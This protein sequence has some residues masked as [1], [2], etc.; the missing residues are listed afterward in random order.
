MPNDHL[1]QFIRDFHPTP[2]VCGVPKNAARQ[3]YQK[4]ENHQRDL[5]TGIIGWAEP[6]NMHLFVNLRCMQ[7]YQNAAALYVGGGLTQDSDPAKEWL[8]TERKSEALGRFLG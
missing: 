6:E 7:I 3:L 2:A 1:W 5:Y 4:Y 8:E